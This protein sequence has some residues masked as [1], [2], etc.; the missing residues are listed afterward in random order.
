MRGGREGGRKGRGEERRGEEGE[1]REEGG[2]H[3]KGL[4]HFLLK[5]IMIAMGTW[6]PW[7]LLLHGIGLA[8][9]LSVSSIVGQLFPFMPLPYP[10]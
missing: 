4:V 7:L 6:L 2:R 3:L 5:W 1:E 10:M 8:D 9:I